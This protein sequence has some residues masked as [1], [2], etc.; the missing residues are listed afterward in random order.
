MSAWESEG[1]DWESTFH[2]LGQ[3]PDE[4]EKHTIKFD[5]WDQ[6]DTK[7]LMKE[8]KEFR[9]EKDLF[10]D[11]VDTGGPFWE[12]MHRALFKVDPEPTND[13]RLR[14]TFQ[15]N[16]VVRD[17]M[18][19]LPEYSELRLMGCEGDDVAAAMG[20]ITMRPAV[21]TIF[22]R[23][24]KEMEKAKELEELMQQCAMAFAGMG[25]A[26]DEE[27]EGEGE[28]GE[29]GDQPG[30]GWGLVKALMNTAG[31][32]RE[33]IDYQQ[34]AKEMQER[35]DQA[36]QDLQ[37]DLDQK[38]PTVRQGMKEALKE[39]LDDA[40]KMQSAADSWGMD[41]GQWQRMDPA[42]RLHWAKR[43]R[44]NNQK[45]EKM[46]ALIGPMKRLAMSKQQRK[47]N[48][49]REEIYDISKGNDLARLLPVQTATL[50]H[51]VL[52]AD[53]LR[54][55]TER[56]LL[57]YELRGTE[58]L[59]KGGI[60]YLDDNSGSMM[61]DREVWAKA[62]GI[63]L[64]TIA[65][66]QKRSFYGIHFGSSYEISEWD[67]TTPEDYNPEKVMQYAE[68]F[69]SGGTD[70]M[71][72]LTRAK[73]LLQEE[74]DREGAVKGDIVFATDGACNVNDKW[75]DDFK[76]DQNRLGFRVFGITIG[77]HPSDEPLNKICDGRVI[78][79]NDL[80]SGDNVADLFGEL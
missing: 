57:Q 63:A 47:I 45:L 40:E 39:A 54:K 36:R 12:D 78:S 43:L 14:P 80:H 3:T 10:C 13:A 75:F 29:P 69:F 24:E 44:Q 49:A 66:S 65:K 58:K 18:M 8:M 46:A 23:L 68:Q 61:G 33:A 6:E 55:F 22:D 28:G 70:F 37:N 26:S 34:K 9:V 51:P 17:E 30:S 11:N 73:E 64:L 38:R 53:F 59:G 35:I 50:H 25:G 2:L 62:V 79:I 72:P 21:E 19:K 60:I 48:N 67:F 16:G 7:R 52:K 42:T 41:P 1:L 5:R 74:F 4:M 32:G 27:G 56:S 20:V 31:Q 76:A 71:T 77:G 15:I